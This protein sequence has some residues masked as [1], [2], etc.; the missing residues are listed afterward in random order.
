MF[1]ISL[2]NKHHLIKIYDKLIRIDSW[3]VAIGFF[4]EKNS[5]LVTSLK[6]TLKQNLESVLKIFKEMKNK[7]D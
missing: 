4:R 1:N 5:V 2:L 6:M 3:S 7:K